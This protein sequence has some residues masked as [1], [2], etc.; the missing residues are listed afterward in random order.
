MTAD[1][2]FLILKT[3]LPHFFPHY[4]LLSSGAREAEYIVIYP[5]VLLCSFVSLLCVEYMGRR[6]LALLIFIGVEWIY[7]VVLISWYTDSDISKYIDSDIYIYILFQI[8]SD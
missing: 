8:L 4:S 1:S 6:T 2:K 7:N 5:S 3:E